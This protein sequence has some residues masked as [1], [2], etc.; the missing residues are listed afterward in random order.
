MHNITFIAFLIVFLI[1]SYAIYVVYSKRN[2]YQIVEK[3]SVPVL[4]AIEY[5]LVLRQN[6]K[7]NIIK[8]NVQKEVYDL[9]ELYNW[10]VIL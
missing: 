4:N 5:Y 3:F 1:I 2:T 7:N 6:K 10:I 8:V 9:Y